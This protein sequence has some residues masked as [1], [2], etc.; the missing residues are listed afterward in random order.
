MSIKLLCSSYSFNS[1]AKVKALCEQTYEQGCQLIPTTLNE[2]GLLS[3]VGQLEPGTTWACWVSLF[4]LGEIEHFVTVLLGLAYSKKPEKLLVLL[5]Q[6]Q[7]AS[8]VHFRIS[9]LIQHLQ[10]AHC[11]TIVLECPLLLNEIFLNQEILEKERLLMLPIGE[12]TLSW[13]SPDEVARQFT[14]HLVYS[15]V[16]MTIRLAEHIFLSGKG[17]AKTL[18]ELLT[19]PQGIEAWARKRLS[20]IDRN[21]DLQLDKEELQYYYLQLGWESGEI[22]VWLKQ[23]LE[24]KSY[25]TLED[26]LHSLKPLLSLDMYGDSEPFLYLHLPPAYSFQEWESNSDVQ[27]LALSRAMEYWEGIMTYGPDREDSFSLRQL[28]QWLETELPHLHQTHILPGLGILKNVSSP[29]RES[30]QILQEMELCSGLRVL[31]KKDEGSKM[32]TYELIQEGESQSPRE[33]IHYEEDLR[34]IALQEGRPVS[35]SAEKDW[36]DW[37]TGLGLLLDRKELS[38]EQI[39]LFRQQG[40]LPPFVV[41]APKLSSLSTKSETFYFAGG[42]GILAAMAMIRSRGNKAQPQPFH[43][44][45]AV[46]NVDSL[47]FSEELAYW[48]SRMEVFSWTPLVTDKIGYVRAI[49]IQQRYPF[50]SGGMAYICGPKDYVKEVFE[51]LRAAG[52]PQSQIR[53]ELFRALPH[54]EI[55]ERIQ[56]P[57]LA[58]QTTPYFSIKP[59]SSSQN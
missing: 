18:S 1:L 23:T 39:N 50:A 7:G 49:E 9:S 17:I 15:Q 55:S 58:P 13:I 40:E 46:K 42:T 22:E 20:C 12:S 45:W 56:A 54:P 14:Y 33:W 3:S 38:V 6:S 37:K 19:H 48:A 36:K 52:W 43:L 34:S 4:D 41:P 53:R 30:K 32:L 16:N 44:D 47:V 26:S 21:E 2:E 31:R 10:N 25:V 11:P 59:I 5:P 35:I 24:S 8:L 28:D 29:N 57:D 27:E 51:G